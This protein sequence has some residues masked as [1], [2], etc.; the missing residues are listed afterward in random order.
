M[1][2]HEL[3]RIIK[4]AILSEMPQIALKGKTATA[5]GQPLKK[6]PVESVAENV[7][8]LH[9]PGQTFF[10]NDMLLVYFMN[11]KESAKSMAKGDI[12]YLKVPVGTFM[13]GGSPITDIWKKKFQQP[14]TEHILGVIEGSAN[15][16]NIWIENMTV[17][18]KYKR[19]SIMTKMLQV[20]KNNWPNAT[21]D[22]S[23]ATEQGKKFIGSTKKEPIQLKGF[24]RVHEGSPPGLDKEDHT[25]NIEAWLNA[26]L[27]ES[28]GEEYFGVKGKPIDYDKLVGVAK[29][30]EAKEKDLKKAATARLSKHIHKS[31]IID[32]QTGEVIDPMVLKK[33][34]MDRPD[35]LVGR[36]E[37][38]KASGGKTFV[39]YD[40]TL[41][42]YKGL[43]V[44]EASPEKELRMINTCPSAGAC[45]IFC[46]A[47]KG[48]Y[49]QWES[50][51]LSAARRLNFLMNDWEGFKAQMINEVNARVKRNKGKYTVIRWHDAGDF[52]SPKYIEVAFEIAKATPRAI[53]Y[54][55][56]KEVNNV[57]QA[58]KPKNF[59]FN[60]SMGGR[61]DKT[62]QKD[63]EKFSDVIPFDV[64]ADLTVGGGKSRTN[65]IQPGK[66]DELKDRVAKVYKLDPRSVVTYDEM[67][68][69]PYDPEADHKPF[70]NVLVWKGHGD[71]AAYRNDVL[72][73]Y[74]LIH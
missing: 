28:K 13:S 26:S 51:G 31:H 47:A 5:D 34:I 20:V 39:I 46:Y 66:E 69:I 57:R 24:D 8:V 14:G 56:T 11:S 42:A 36:N 65:K 58:N 3:K 10:G 73:T 7:V 4:E 54:A 9:Q 37:K 61:Q 2:K 32:K 33:K 71:D 43:Y 64:F 38:M 60:F 70:Y 74:L 41:P 16:E 40:T 52:F 15:D 63:T 21:V 35:A 49:I 22:Y 55:Y 29:G 1:K 18:P 72:G 23:K 67:M 62:I 27:D 25:A 30:G 59:T 48:G 68:N 12:P 50:S 19:N 44:D 17:R 6:L 53:H 45:S